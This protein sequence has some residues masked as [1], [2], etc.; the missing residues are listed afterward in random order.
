MA[1][2]G[3]RRWRPLQ[4]PDLERCRFADRPSGN[5]WFNGS[6]VTVRPLIVESAKE[7][8]RKA[9]EVHAGSR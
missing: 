4:R 1:Y 2:R 3:G 5:A 9:A 8:D 6:N 7:L